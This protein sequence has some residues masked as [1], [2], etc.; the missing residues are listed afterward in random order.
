MALVLQLVDEAPV[1]LDQPIRR[2]LPEFAV[3]D[4]ELS[5]AVTVRHF[6]RHTGGFDGDVF[7]DTGRGDDA[8]DKTPPA[9]LAS[10][11]TDAYPGRYAGPMLAYEVAAVS[12][13]LD[14]TLIPSDFA[15]GLGMTGSTARYVPLAGE[16]FIFSAD[17]M[18]G[19]HQVLT[20][21]DGGR[22]LHNGRALPRVG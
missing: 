1:D 10:L 12:G 8:L 14:I 9:E 7:R 3:A 11:P 4:P 22:Y 21:V 16:A 6:V 18:D 13:G 5:A 17:P 15:R 19:R 20:F 2:Y